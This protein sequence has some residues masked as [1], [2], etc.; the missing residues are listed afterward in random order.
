MAV[1]CIAQAIMFGASSALVG[2]TGCG[3]GGNT[4]AYASFG[5]VVGIEPDPAAVRLARER[6]GARAFQSPYLRIRR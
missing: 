3:T 2:Y 6:G 4:P 5:A 1:V